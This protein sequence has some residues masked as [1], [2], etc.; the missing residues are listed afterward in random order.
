[1][2]KVKKAKIHPTKKKQ[3]KSEQARKKFSSS[4]LEE[5][6]IAA[7]EL[8]DAKFVECV[9]GRTRRQ[10]DAG[11][12]FFRQYDAFKKDQMTTLPF[13]AQQH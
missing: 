6:F 8:F 10:P 13:T 11:G 2:K 7:V 3:E 12:H 5:K 9:I 4:L 1:V